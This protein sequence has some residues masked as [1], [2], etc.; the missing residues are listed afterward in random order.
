MSCA[1][2]IHK[3]HMPIRIIYL[4]INVV[5]YLCCLH[6]NSCTQLLCLNNTN[7]WINRF[8]TNL[9]WTHEAC[10]FVM[11]WPLCLN[12]WAMKSMNYF[13]LKQLIKKIVLT[14][15]QTKHLIKKDISLSRWHRL[16]QID[17]IQWLGLSQIT[18]FD[19]TFSQ[20][21]HTKLAT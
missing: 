6:I 7:L 1:L 20:I 13:I 12:V 10:K 18:H 5:C 17:Y 15:L 8:H 2:L 3:F 9:E 16:S 14:T 11:G 4:N 19:L 21:N